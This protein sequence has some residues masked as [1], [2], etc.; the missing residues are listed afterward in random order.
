[1]ATL[2]IVRHGETDWNKE[3]KV[4]GHSDIPLNEYG[5]HL[6]EETAEG[7]K[8]VCFALAYTSPLKR[9]EETAKI[10][11]RDRKT[12]LIIDR[13]IKEL[14]FGDYEGMCCSG[15]EKDVRSM[16]F[17][18]FF[19]DTAN[20]IPKGEGETIQQLY[21]RIGSFLAEIC[22]RTDLEGKNILVSTHGAAMTAL[23]N[24]I[25]KNTEI[26]EFWKYEV[27]P[28]CAVTIVEIVDG[29]PHIA[30]EGLIYYKEA[31]KRWQVE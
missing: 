16:E 24:I 27:P 11:L 21:K 23:L 25:R 6:A 15:K 5:R 26:K 4:Q 9:A 18:K 13:R 3:R 12:P 29:T 19:K 1:M 8:D 28:N 31:V 10:L 14:G 22:T 30:Q 7:L 2:Y 20:Y 17:N